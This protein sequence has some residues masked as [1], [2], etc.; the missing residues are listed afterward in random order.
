[1]KKGKVEKIIADRADALTPGISAFEEIDKKTNWDKVASYSK[2]KNKKR[3]IIPLAI[4]GAASLVVGIVVPI[5]YWMSAS[6]GPGGIDEHEF[7][8]VVF[9][10]FSVSRWETTNPSIDLTASSLDVSKTTYQGGPG[11]A[12]LRDE[13]SNSTPVARFIGGSFASFEFNEFVAD[14]D[15]FVGTATYLGVHY[16]LDIFFLLENR[17]HETVRITFR[18]EE[19]DTGYAYY[20]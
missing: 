12:L 8:H 17:K 15:K 14:K 6:I 3:F 9:G 5:S 2:N 20:S 16:D 11:C 13:R 4:L 18:S 7:T 10:I 19:K 1:M